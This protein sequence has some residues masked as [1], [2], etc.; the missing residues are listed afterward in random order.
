MRLQRS[1]RTP[2]PSREVPPK[3]RRRVRIF[4]AAATGLA[5][6]ASGLGFA[7]TA[8]AADPAWMDTSLSADKRAD[9]LAAAMTFDQKLTLFAGSG[10][11]AVAIPELGIPARREIDGASGVILARGVETT[12]FPAGQAIAST[13]D[14]N[15]ARAFGK[16]AGLEAHLTGFSGWAGPSADLRRTP[17]HGRQWAT[18]GEDPLL[19]GLLPAAVVEG[20]NDNNDTAGVYSLPKHFVANNQET[21]RST[22]DTVIDER[23]LRELYVRQWEPVVDADPGAIMCAY[24][25]VNG[26][27]ACE[28]PALLWDVLKGEL[29]FPG[30]VSSD[31]NAC[32]SLQAYN[33][34]ADV[35]GPNFPT[36]AELRRAVENGTIDRGR[37]DDMVHRVLRTYFKHGL[38]DNP[39][40]GSLQ[41]PKPAAQP[42]PA[43]VIEQGQNAAYRIAVDGSVLLRNQNRALPLNSDKLK[44]ITVIGEAAD[45]YITGFGSDIVVNPT[46]TSTILDGIKDRAGGAEVTHIDGWDPTRP[47]DLLPG[48]QPIPSGVLR[49]ADGK[50]PGLTGEWFPTASFDTP[51]ATTR[52]DD[53]VNWGQGLTGLLATFGY[54]PSPA[55]KLPAVATFAGAPTATRWT[56]TLNPTESGTYSLGFTA[57]GSARMWIDGEEVIT[58]DANTLDTFAIERRLE[59]G[60]SY[61]IR[62]DYV[63]DAPNQCCITSAGLGSAI[64]LTWTPPNAAASP[65]IAEAVAAASES[66][67]AL[68]VADDYMGESLDR[69][70]LELSQNQDLLIEAVT[71]ANPN[72]IVILTTGTGVEL[73]WLD[74]AAAVM[75]AWYPGQAQGRAVAAL[76]FGDEN[77]SG[78]LPITWPATT[79]Q[80]T[81]ELGIE[82]PVYD[83]NNPGVTVE[84]EEGVNIGYRGYD[85]LGI[86]PLFEFGYGLSYTSF[87]YQRVTV[88]DPVARSEGGDDEYKAGSVEVLV[89]NTGRTTGTETVNLYHGELPTDRADTP[90]RQLLGWGRI[91]LKPGAS[92]V[93]TIPIDLYSST[94]KLAYWDSE[95]NY[96]ITPTGETDLFVG[97]SSRDIRLTDSINVQAPDTS[98]P[99]VT[100]TPSPAEPTGRSGWYRNA[101]ELTITAED[102]DTVKL[103]EASVDG[104]KFTKVTK[105]IVIASDGSHTVRARATDVS[106]NVSE[107]VEWAGKIDRT[108]PTVTAKFQD[109]RRT[110]ALTAR[111]KTSGVASI[112]Y[113][114]QVRQGTNTTWGPWRTYNAPIS[115]P[116]G[117]NLALEYRSI[118]AAGNVSNVGR[119]R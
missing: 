34:G 39:P 58:A 31:F 29:G 14:T 33:L 10:D 115:A 84:F 111:D 80:V 21:A 91:T 117:S 32:V 104:K 96:W 71:A 64:R 81:D 55:P 110:V 65:Q 93:V 74:D 6:V 22:M 20:V 60:E 77:F 113:R 24:P 66:D 44:S 9:L 28:N 72:T 75:E 57:L 107:V 26:S 62:I 36:S 97:A 108:S 86:E 59:A 119:V 49:A 56:G 76:L 19:G 54:E 94:H 68:I 63:S 30:W 99:T 8:Y 70:H 87:K 7:G 38:I 45:R 61:D 51:P 17:F 89:R 78:K 52:V 112:E 37:F 98:A 79:E 41:N 13:W 90:P 50:T 73:P 15:L 83:V 114:Y 102:D 47:G 69:G 3:R 88:T 42:L 106:G 100:I 27:K 101:V 46:E 118:D 109:Q 40:P 11:G 103:V 12:A 116:R 2:P 82:N 1:D 105:P 18:Y 92:G 23:T 53:Q 16:Q 5:V 43:S 35:C 95:W 25:R 4:L 85:E 48:A 67:V